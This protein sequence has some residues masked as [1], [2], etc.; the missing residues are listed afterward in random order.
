MG[1]DTATSVGL[2]SEYEEYP[3]RRND[4]TR[5]PFL[6]WS[7]SNK[8]NQKDGSVTRAP[9]GSSKENSRSTWL[10]AQTLIWPKRPL[11]PLLLLLPAK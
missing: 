2:V 6:S 4:S 5:L 8:L 1:G 11:Q 7:R 3:L 10:L 9:A